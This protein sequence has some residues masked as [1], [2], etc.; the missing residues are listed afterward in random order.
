MNDDSWYVV[1]NTPGVTGFVGAN[2]MPTPLP[3]VEV[4]KLLKHLRTEE[5]AING[6][7]KVGQKV[8]I[9]EGPYAD[10]VGTVEEV[11]RDQARVKVHIKVFGQE[12]PLEFDFVQ[13]EPL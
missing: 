4:N 13:V 10:F 5:P 12:K 7:F 2:N 6:S 11:D 3:P 1:R 9:V 8:R